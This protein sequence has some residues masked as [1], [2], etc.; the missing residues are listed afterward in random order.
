MYYFNSN[1][2]YLLDK[3]NISIPELA[4]HLSLT[5]QCVSHYI[6]SDRVPHISILIKIA[7]LFNISLDDLILTNLNK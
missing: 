3:F 5:R 7:D 6:H 2:K 4:K 1:L